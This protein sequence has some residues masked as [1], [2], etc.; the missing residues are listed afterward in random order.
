MAYV[1]KY[2]DFGKFESFK[3]YF[4]KLG[5]KIMVAIGIFDDPGTP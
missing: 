5:P 4:H 1:D 2:H 3:A